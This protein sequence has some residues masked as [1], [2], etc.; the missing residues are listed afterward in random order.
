MA[1]VASREVLAGPAPE[2]VE[3]LLEVRERAGVDVEFVTRSFFSTLEYDAQLEL[4]QQ[5]AEEVAPHL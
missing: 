5:L 4:M 3:K 2:I 1:K